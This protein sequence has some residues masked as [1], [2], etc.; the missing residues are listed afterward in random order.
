VRDVVAQIIIER[1]RDGEWREAAAGSDG[2]G[3]VRQLDWSV[4]APQMGKLLRE[5]SAGNR[6]DKFVGGISISIRDVVV[7]QDNPC[8]ATRR[9]YHEQQGQPQNRL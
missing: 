9:A 6:R 3:K 1:Q 8:L 5:P 7:H 4:M 2:S